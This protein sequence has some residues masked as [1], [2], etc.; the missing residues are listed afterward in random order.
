MNRE[1]GWSFYIGFS[2]VGILAAAV[3]YA[4]TLVAE[5]MFRDSQSR[6]NQR[7][8]LRWQRF[9]FRGHYPL[10]AGGTKATTEIASGLIV[11][12]RI[13]L[14]LWVVLLVVFLIRRAVTGT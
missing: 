2:A 12:V 10:G 8:F 3:M 11:A 1:P 7:R 4:A 5:K 14:V 6:R 13:F 9:L